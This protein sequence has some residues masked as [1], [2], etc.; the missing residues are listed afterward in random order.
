M[1]SNDQC[2]NNSSQ[3]QIIEDL[4]D[5]MCSHP[6]NSSLLSIDNT[7]SS[8]RTERTMENA[9]TNRVKHVALSKRRE[10]YKKQM[11]DVSQVVQAPASSQ[12]QQRRSSAGDA[13]RQTA[14]DDSQD[15]HSTVP[16]RG[17]QHQGIDPLIRSW[18]GG[19]RLDDLPSG[20]T[21]APSVVS[22]LSSSLPPGAPSTTT[23]TI[24]PE[25]KPKR[26]GPRRARRVSTESDGS[27]SIGELFNDIISSA[28]RNS[29]SSLDSDAPRSSA[30]NN[31]NNNS[32]GLPKPSYLPAKSN[33][34]RSPVGE[35]DRPSPWSV[36]KSVA[37]V[38]V[39]AMANTQDQLFNSDPTLLKEEST[40]TPGCSSS[41]STTPASISSRS[42]SSTAAAS[43]SK[44]SEQQQPAN[45][46]KS[47]T[48]KPRRRSRRSTVEGTPPSQQTLSSQEPRVTLRRKYQPR[49]RD[50]TYT[51]G[52]VQGIVKP[53]KYTRAGGGSFSESSTH[54]FPNSPS[55]ASNNTPPPAGSANNNR[56]RRARRRPSSDQLSSSFSQLLP[57]EINKLKSFRPELVPCSDISSSGDEAE[58]AGD[59]QEFVSS[60]S[61]STINRRSSEGDKDDVWVP[62]GVDFSSCMEVYVFEKWI[63]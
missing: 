63:G 11:G 47:L 4:D 12:Q 31:N 6:F 14:D 8:L 48:D 5:I 53:S 54:S 29:D 59:Q 62:H 26:Q 39:N 1:S 21:G 13:D 36:G 50:L 43:S 44:Q 37:E 28:K 52:S 34:R 46:N 17:H 41:E 38:D 22:S 40:Y 33:S 45:N 51:S 32:L 61:T 60:S 20:A 35:V 9:L 55:V 24:M 23:T 2:T 56:R 7:D 18:H 3:D 19:F 49:H 42:S 30:N 16:P 57:H 58:Q 25:Y 15:S 27:I 10:Q